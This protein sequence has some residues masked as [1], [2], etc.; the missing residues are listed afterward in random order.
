MVIPTYTIKRIKP[1]QHTVL[2]CRISLYYCIIQVLQNK[3]KKQTILFIL[4]LLLTGN[5]LAAECEELPGTRIIDRSITL[6]SDTY[7]S[8]EGIKITE[9]NVELNCGTGIIRGNYHKGIGITIADRKNI[10]ITRCNVMTYNV[11]VFISNSS[12]VHLYDNALLKN[13]VG[14]RMYNAHENIIEKHN[15]KSLIKPISALTSKFNIVMLGNK[16]ID[17]EFC[18]VN[19]CNNY[20]DMNPC[21]N[22]DF[23]CSSRCTPETDN[24]CKKEKITA[25]ATA[26]TKNKTEEIAEKPEPLEITETKETIEETQTKKE[27]K[28]NIRFIAYPIFYLLG[29]LI[30]Q[31]IRYVKEFDRED[32]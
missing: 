8:L 6:C 12:K 19:A 29:L 4:C 5:V 31:F 20:K 27:E 11:G 1:I 26:K 10:T 9:D 13:D 32:I 14:V 30:F 17:R 16:N 7:D 15:D 21:E 18:E 25:A 3:M 23:Y 22:N 24:D 2:P 28:N